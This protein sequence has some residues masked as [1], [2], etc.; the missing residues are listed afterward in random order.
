[1]GITIKFKNSGSVYQ[2]YN[3]PS[4]IETPQ[5][6]LNPTPF[7]APAA[8]AASNIPVATPKINTGAISRDGF[9][10][11]EDLSNKYGSYE[12]YLESFD[13]EANTN[14]ALNRFQFETD[15]SGSGTN[16]REKYGT[17]ENY[18]NEVVSDQYYNNV[19]N[20]ANTKLAWGYDPE[21]EKVEL[22]RTELGNLNTVA[23]AAAAKGMTIEQYQEWQRQENLK[24]ELTRQVEI[25]QA[26]IETAAGSRDAIQN[27]INTLL[28]PNYG[29]GNINLSATPR[30]ENEDG[31]YSTVDSISFY[32][33]RTGLEILIPTVVQIDGEWQHVSAAQAIE[34]Y[35][36]T[37]KYLGAFHSAEEA[38]TYANLLHEQQE[39]L[40]SKHAE[41]SARYQ[42]A[43]DLVNSMLTEFEGGVYANYNA[44]NDTYLIKYNPTQYYLNKGLD[45]TELDSLI[46]SLDAY[47]STLPA[48]D[49]HYVDVKRRRDELYANRMLFGSD[50]ELK[51]FY[52]DQKY[53]KSSAELTD[54]R[55]KL[56][57]RYDLVGGD[58]NDEE[59]KRLEAEVAE[60][61]K[62]FGADTN[63]RDMAGKE[64]ARRDALYVVQN[65]QKVGDEKSAAYL[66]LLANY[67]TTG[68]VSTDML[69]NMGVAW[70]AMQA[71]TPEKI[72]ALTK[73]A[74]IDA[75][76]DE[77]VAAN[78]VETILR[79][80][81]AKST[82]SMTEDFR[83]LASS[84]VLGGVAATVLS[85]GTNAL[86]GLGM[87]EGIRALTNG[88]T[89]NYAD[90]NSSFFAAANATN[91][92]RGGVT[93]S[94]DWKVGS[95]DLFDTTYGIITSSVDS[96]LGAYMGG[97]AGGALIG[98][99]AA[100]QAMLETT[101]NGGTLSDAIGTGIMAGIFESL[102]ET[103]SIS[104]FR[105]L[106]E[107]DIAAGTIKELLSKAH[108]GEFAK[109]VGK[110]FITNASEEAFT[111]AANIIFDYMKNTPT[112]NY[113]REIAD[114]MTQ[115]NP[116]TGKLY[117][118]DEAK[119]RVAINDAKQVLQAGITGGLQGILMGSFAQLGAVKTVATIREYVSLTNEQKG[120][121]H[122]ICVGE[123]YNP[124]SNTFHLAQRLSQELNDAIGGA[125]KSDADRKADIIK[126]FQE[127]QQSFAELDQSLADEMKDYAPETY[128]PELYK[129]SKE[130]AINGDE[131]APHVEVPTETKIRE[132]QSTVGMTAEEADA[133]KSLLF[134][135][136]N[137]D[138]K[139]N[140]TKAQ[141]AKMLQ[142][143]SFKRAVFELTG[144]QVEGS[145]L[146][147]V[148]RSLTSIAQQIGESETIDLNPVDQTLTAQ[149]NLVP[150]TENPEAQ[151]AGNFNALKSAVSEIMAQQ[152]GVAPAADTAQN[153]Y[154]SAWY[155][156]GQTNDQS[157]SIPGLQATM[158]GPAQ[159]APVEQAPPQTREEYRAGF[160]KF[161][162][163]DEAGED[164]GVITK[165]QHLSEQILNAMLA[166]SG[167]KVKV[168]SGDPSL[169]GANGMYVDGTLYVNG[170][171]REATDGKGNRVSVD[172]STFNGIAWIV[173]HEMTH[174][175]E[176]RTGAGEKGVVSR[177]F[178]AMKSLADEGILSE[179][180][181]KAATDPEAMKAL[182]NKYRE[183]YRR[184]LIQREY[185]KFLGIGVAP[186]TAK[187]LAIE[188]ASKDVDGPA[189]DKYVNAEIAGDFMGSIFGYHTGRENSGF[190]SPG[191]RRM[192]ALLK[193]AS[194]DRSIVE[195]AANDVA[196]MRE[197]AGEN[198]N[199]KAERDALSDLLLDLGAAL[200][201]SDE[202]RSEEGK[203][204]AA[205]I[206]DKTFYDQIELAC[207]G[208]LSYKS[209]M[210][211]GSPAKLYTDMGLPSGSFYIDQYKFFLCATRSNKD[212][213]L[214]K[215]NWKTGNLY[216]YIN[217][218]AV[219]YEVMERMPD[220]LADPALVY[221]SERRTAA[222]G[223]NSS[224]SLVVVTSELDREGYP[225]VAIVTPAGKAIS[226]FGTEV[227]ANFV[228]SIYGLRDLFVPTEGDN[229]SALE[230]ARDENRILY[231]GKN[232]S[233]RLAQ[234]LEERFPDFFSSDG[235]VSGSITDYLPDVD[236]DKI[237]QKWTPVV[238]QT[239]NRPKSRYSAADDGM[240]SP[241]EN[242]INGLQTDRNDRLNAEQLMGRLRG[243]S[244]V[245]EEAKTI[246]LPEYLEGRQF[247]SKSELLDYVQKN[248]FKLDEVRRESGPEYW[249]IQNK[250]SGAVYGNAAELD[251]D[252]RA[253]AANR[254]LR[255]DGYRITG[256][257]GGL[258]NLSNGAI[259]Q[260][261]TAYGSDIFGNQT[262]LFKAD[263][264]KIGVGG[265]RFND[266]TLMGGDNY[267]EQL[268]VVPN[269][270][271]VSPGARKHW[272]DEKGVLMHVRTKDF[273]TASGSKVLVIEEMQSDWHNDGSK[274]GYESKGGPIPDAPYRNSYT[275]YLFNRMLMRAV[276]EDYDMVAWT[277]SNSQMYRGNPYFEKNEKGNVRGLQ[278]YAN[279]YDRDLPNLARKYG[280]IETVF[281]PKASQF[282]TPKSYM[283][284]LGQYNETNTRL[285]ELNEAMRTGD[286]NSAESLI[287]NSDELRTLND[288][289]S[290]LS[291]QL[292]EIKNSGVMDTQKGVTV[293]GIRVTD[294]LMDRVWDGLPRFSAA[295][296]GPDGMYSALEREIENLP[297]NKNGEIDTKNL[298]NVL[299]NRAQKVRGLGDEI[300]WSQ[301]EDL[302]KEYDGQ[303]APKEDILNAVK[304]V[305]GAPVLNEGQRNST[306]NGRFVFYKGP[307]TG[308]VITDDFDAAVE[309][310]VPSWYDYYGYDTEEY[311]DKDG[312]PVLNPY[313]G[314]VVHRR[315]INAFDPETGELVPVDTVLDYGSS[316]PHGPEHGVWDET[317]FREYTL[318]GGDDYTEHVYTLP[319]ATYGGTAEEMHWDEP[320]VLLHTR[321]QTMHTPDGKKVLFI[322]EVQSDWHNDASKNGY[323]SKGGEVP[324][325][326]YGKTYTEYA[327]KRM[328]LKAAQ[329]GYDYIA[330]TTPEM[331][332]DRW[333]PWRIDKDL[334]V[335]S[336]NPKY[337]KGYYSTYG[338][339]LPNAARRYGQL[340]NVALDGANSRPYAGADF[341]LA[342]EKYDKAYE[343]LERADR[344]LNESEDDASFEA[345]SKEYDEAAELVRQAEKE[346]DAV[347]STPLYGG[348]A[349][350]TAPGIEITPELRERI[351][352][353]GLPRYSVAGE[354][355]ASEDQEIMDRLS[356]AK[357]WRREGRSAE[358][359]YRDTRSNVKGHK[360]TGWWYDPTDKKWRFEISDKEAMFMPY[361]DA[362]RYKNDED[363]KDLKDTY[364][365]LKKKDN[366][367]QLSKN[368]KEQFEA[369]KKMFFEER[370]KIKESFQKNGGT[371]GDVLR[372]EE[373]YRL[374][375][376][377]ENAKIRYE[378]IEDDPDGSR[379]YGYFE[380]P[381]KAGE[382]GTIVINSRYWSEKNFDTSAKNA[383]E[384]V[385]STI[386]HEVQHMI[387]R[388]EGF[389]PGYNTDRA[390]E[391]QDQ[392]EQNLFKAVDNFNK[393]TTGMGSVADR[394]RRL[395]GEIV[396]RKGTNRIDTIDPNTG[397]ILSIGNNGVIELPENPKKN[398][399]Y[400]AVLRYAKGL[401]DFGVI[402][403]DQYDTI[404]GKA[405]QDLIQ[406]SYEY[407]YTQ[408]VD[409]DVAS[410]YDL[411]AAT[412]GEQEAREVQARRDMNISDREKNL[413]MLPT[414]MEDTK[415]PERLNEILGKRY[416]AVDET[417]P[418]DSRDALLSD[419]LQRMNNTRYSAAMPSGYNGGETIDYEDWYSTKGTTDRQ[420]ISPEQLNET[421]GYR[422]N[423]P[424]TVI[425][426]TGTKKG[427]V[428]ERGTQTIANSPVTTDEM[429]ESL[430]SAVAN[431]A[432]QHMP[433]TDTSA[434]DKASK[435]I[436]RNGWAETYGKY[437][438]DVMAGKANKDITTM[439][440]ALY[441]N[442][443]TAGAITDAMD[444]ASLMIK[445]S[446]SVGAALQAN[447]MLNKL[448]PDGKLYMA[449]RSLENIADQV[450][451]IYGDEHQFNIS[452]ALLDD[453]RQALVNEDEK[454]QK[455]AWKAIQQEMARQLPDDWKLKLNNWRYLAMLGNPRTHIRNIVGNLGFAPVHK[456]EQRLKAVMERMVLG[457]A[458]EGSN[459]TTAWVSR[460]NSEDRARLAAGK[461]DYDNVVELIQNGGKMRGDKAEI[462]DLRQIYKFKPLEKVREWNTKLLDKEDT[463]FS[464]PAYADAL[465]SFMKAR[466]IDGDAF[467]AGNVAP[468]VLNAAR[469]YAIKEAQKAT[470]RDSNAFSD[471]V[472]SLGKAGR[473]KNASK[474]QKAA[475][476]ALEA[477]LPFKKTPANILMRAVEYSPLEFGQ[478]L[479]GD[480]K[481]IRE[482]QAKTNEAIANS[483][484]SETA[485]RKINQMREN[486]SLMVSQMLDH[487]SSG[488]TG[489]ALMG[490]GILLSHMGLIVGGKDPDKE[491]A[492]LDEL[493]GTQEYSANLNFGDLGERWNSKFLMN[494]G[495][496]NY[497]I[498]WLAPEALPLF[499]GVTLF[500]KLK[501]MRNRDDSESDLLT[502]AWDLIVGMGEPMLNMSMLSSVNDL[503]SKMSYLDDSSQLPALLGQIGYSYVSQYIPTL[504]GQ[505]ERIAETRRESTYY[506]RDDGLSKDLQYMLG[507]T[508]NKIPVWDYNQIPYL[509]AWG[510][511]QETGNILGRAFANLVSPGYIRK[512]ETTDLEDELKRMHDLGYEK[513]I[514][515]RTTQSTKVD[516]EYMNEEEYVTYARTKGQKS[517]EDL[518]ALTESDAYKS[519][520]DEQKA[521]A[522]AKI[523]NSA[524]VLA[525]DEVRKL[526]GEKVEG[527]KA[528]DAGMP[529]AT[530]SAA[531]TIYETATA[532]SWYKETDEDGKQK[533]PGWSKAL[534]VLDND[535]LSKGDRLKY[536][537]AI[538]TRKEPFGSFNEAKEYYTEARDDAKETIRLAPAKN[539]YENAKT[540]EGYKKTEAGNTPGWAKMLAL[541]DDKSVN[542]DLKL[543]YINKVCG[544][545]ED[546]SSLSDAR[547]YYE[548]KKKKAKE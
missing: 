477:V 66:D 494:I 452:N 170:D 474:V 243:I 304:Y 97:P 428:T 161:S 60:A 379:T 263:S 126:F 459:R 306:Q 63:Q 168:V 143:E 545:K 264:T 526:R 398:E 75:G 453:Y 314:E 5:V 436:E 8:P 455:E 418:A 458:G 407:R 383:D 291:E 76:V 73:Q 41:L 368:Q 81:N 469:E 375:P 16:L 166:G 165:E 353:E 226:K 109:N 111:E 434:Y 42:A 139:L 329:E 149:D 337:A 324:D 35:R 531:K 251:Q 283:D 201:F 181:A 363:Y 523:Y 272:G 7:A 173:G 96:M 300:K 321:E 19:K 136:V 234:R 397:E 9:A 349:V 172:A 21:R 269:S 322:E 121:V 86:S 6:K 53:E 280:E 47:L 495:N 546:F 48:G 20:T 25:E 192:D 328:L 176:E 101:Q 313:T 82:E 119:A 95:V 163:A 538:S 512:T 79:E 392:A 214:D 209:D 92:L 541:L 2:D 339:D 350:E 31:T 451:S 457:K 536:I 216:E 182:Q 40:F 199:S 271:Y 427:Y 157:A 489:T 287:Q 498:D 158:Q 439:G 336:D 130:A 463:W 505:A 215:N 64:I 186:E 403:G 515:Q 117:T 548:D 211:I 517:L 289:L 312:N 256:S 71:Y 13:T 134:S 374:Y 74:L 371:V 307:Q 430:K 542:D 125:G 327:L 36:K 426:E 268:Y 419:T 93:D 180:W 228:D 207:T 461:A 197:R 237:I 320:G 247:I 188:K 89:I 399:V 497:T 369:V 116:N 240:Y 503:I 413:M 356:D 391:V 30:F 342:Y 248:E 410:S 281:L 28:A 370:D 366:R 344:L 239:R 231:V 80:G 543:E 464:R 414:G 138:S 221:F 421:S 435:E 330:W 87:L 475:S 507:K 152:N 217:Y 67:S 334:N 171:M 311:L 27:E 358:Q 367:N 544:L 547:K 448:T 123:S 488:L 422:A 355:G 169:A 65:I 308:Q 91:A 395:V 44:V 288:K 377:I 252:A 513:M 108:I 202:N 77:Q 338:R 46:G 285:N 506:D 480:I 160:T 484:G 511:E 462:E 472:A 52:D 442:A 26:K 49:P 446:S 345:A 14:T 301:L 230:L 404:K 396:V 479:F 29:A 354:V 387:Q 210:R 406:A 185:A 400:N 534:A 220:L 242:A 293:Q 470:Y 250:E 483:D 341:Y 11:D 282:V 70:Q 255:Y 372:H 352:N 360:T 190:G 78:T 361:A 309:S 151:G 525:E 346:Y 175:L 389:M 402:T 225:V 233:Q 415:R 135:I 115:I 43:N 55:M 32:D 133:T 456:A 153:D 411:Y 45:Y 359:V 104:Q 297:T 284:L 416:S 1:M 218:H 380:P 527:T 241:L 203:Y 22:A 191:V 298:L 253:A 15:R 449:I 325:A 141:K 364:N 294:D 205:D 236:S 447:R 528:S 17:Y 206:Q 106:Q 500:N 501:A 12:Q 244:G 362:K 533:I 384:A 323:E 378:R 438:A 454:A 467:A 147:E 193:L 276:D 499:T 18:Q 514:P 388:I 129:A 178:D 198:K 493:Q 59:Y 292:N 450:R 3:N 177:I 69:R 107:N 54:L 68:V 195:R 167:V 150:P 473:Q 335:N 183:Q 189:G 112:S 262:E 476:T 409:G 257:D 200:Y 219:P 331:Q 490:L 37:G 465:A 518:T 184:F 299:K 132:T 492:A 332:L 443:V 224:N 174:A 532:P 72:A 254:G 223:N 260:T 516:Q 279:E 373:L 179:E 102:F 258:I 424:A 437:R 194:A 510:R 275:K 286:S 417:G 429:N 524:K 131:T 423:R 381:K 482:A 432:Y 425:P 529:E 140:F 118:E 401:R 408:F 208:Q 357:R 405:L 113:V 537:N 105:A 530:F 290:S 310:I 266:V 90:P 154:Q 238:N 259:R 315:I 509:D 204:S 162:A 83:K 504:L 164:T 62:T 145:T 127:N 156:M 382:L 270:D 386:L 249:V 539:V 148:K 245:A 487:I 137:G 227:K 351:L 267:T 39:Q 347:D 431:G 246:G 103:I 88:S 535:S 235:E 278:G 519:M 57:E 196:D 343:K 144:Q 333:N 319:G 122:A 318:T 433:Y 273:K 265:T 326:P 393:A 38:N 33:D 100:S 460:L 56:Q 94:V 58:T 232:A 520:T 85:F 348:D 316:I 390:K 261:Y 502:D 508:A 365:D 420:Y 521:K 128:T 10:M 110:S 496:V 98:L 385:R 445:N 51:G 481:K 340:I 412:H 466:G 302:L 229:L 394:I 99:Q 114:M 124:S 212:D 61:E 471:W 142:S 441:N 120:V 277:N 23:S 4:Q 303:R 478:V 540:P 486:Q 296:T 305:V 187:K 274:E 34:Q 159:Q 317:R 295:D 468:D 222:N 213:M 50:A 440:I 491:E 155:D 444:I 24:R 485:L 84:G 376:Q 522:I 146:S